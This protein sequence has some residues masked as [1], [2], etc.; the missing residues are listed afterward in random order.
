MF[1]VHF[2]PTLKGHG[3]V[4]GWLH[5]RDADHFPA[6]ALYCLRLGLCVFVL[7]GDVQGKLILGEAKK[8]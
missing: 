3:P 4:L 1:T 5:L 6:D 7:H 2:I 8:L